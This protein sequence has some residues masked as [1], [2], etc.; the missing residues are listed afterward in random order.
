MSSRT[1]IAITGLGPIS[2]I[3]IGKDDFWSGLS[4]GKPNVK[5]EEV[6]IDGEPW[7]SFFLHKVEDFNIHD[8]GI[9]EAKLNDIREWK[10]GEEITD[11]NYL[12][13]AVKLALDDAGI[14]YSAGDSGLGL[15]L[16][17][18]N[19][20]LMPFG[21]KISNLA[22]EILSGKKKLS[23]KDFFNNLYKSF[24]KSGYDIQTFADLFHVARV[25]NIHNYSL[26]INNACASGLYAFEAGAE[27]IRNGQAKAVVVAA[28]DN[29]EI[30]K[31]LWFRDLGI[32]S[33]SGLVRPFCK[34]SDGLVFGDGG[35]G[36]VLEDMASAKKRRAKIYAEYLGGGFDLEGWKI[37]V[38]QIGNDSYV[39][40]INKAFKNSKT[41]EADIDLLVPHGVGSQPIDY[42]EA[43]AIIAT[44][45]N[46]PKKPLI[47][48]LKPYVGHNLGS[49]ALLES[50][51]M[52]LCLNNDTVFPALNYDNP[53][54]KFNIML[55]K[56]KKQVKLKAAMKICCAFAGFNAA[57]VFRR[58]S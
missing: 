30:Y 54:P 22:Y 50:L 51:V 11:L 14:D 6:F 34:D 43:K 18:E 57:A 24:L 44:F 1:R 36:I 39:K 45:G 19:I 23:K 48:A 16:A 8:F 20:G 33:K 32:Y 15:V 7:D 28:A 47:S 41:R 26:F 10:E 29:P 13:A 21:L 42:Y 27:I 49:S 56:E 5:K 37:T 12:L 17:H 2:S 35:A 46:N 4:A 58:V 31:Y 38:P 52:L 25:F 3:G 53:D 9:D 55:N 40:A